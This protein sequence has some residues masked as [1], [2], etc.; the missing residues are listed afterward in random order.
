MCLDKKSIKK[1]DRTNDRLFTKEEQELFEDIMGHVNI[2]AEEMEVY[3]SM[4][5]KV[6]NLY[7]R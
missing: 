6:K 3:W 4:K 1:P 7:V 2:D 5:E